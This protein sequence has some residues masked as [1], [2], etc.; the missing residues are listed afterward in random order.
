MAC[1]AEDKE[2]KFMCTVV[3][4]QGQ[5]VLATKFIRPVAPPSEV[6]HLDEEEDGDNLVFMVKHGTSRTDSA[7]R[8]ERS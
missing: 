3:N 6:L 8:K 5:L 4:R 7:R 2:K 1:R